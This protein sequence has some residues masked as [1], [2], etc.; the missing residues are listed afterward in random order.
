MDIVTLLKIIAIVLGII[1]TSIIPLVIKLRKAI[2]ARN[3]AKTEAEKE[4]AKND[5]LGVL[6]GFIEAAEVLYKDIDLV[7]KQ[8]G[9]S[10]GAVKK[11]SVLTKLQAYAI[12]KGYAFDADYWSATNDNIVALTRK[13]NAKNNG[14]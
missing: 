8:N 7:V 9:A 13:V 12:E 5:M 11:D 2:K 1:S 4:A 6:N 14:Q 3:N 10:L